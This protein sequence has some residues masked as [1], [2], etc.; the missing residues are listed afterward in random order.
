MGEVG[1]G[2]KAGAEI[3]LPQKIDHENI[4]MLS[5]HIDFHEEKKSRS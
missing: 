4:Y 1:D 3:E 2:R 5:L